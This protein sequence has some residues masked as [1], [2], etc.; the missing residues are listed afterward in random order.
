MTG[1]FYEHIA[2]GAEQSGISPEEALSRARDMGYE[3]LECDLWRLQTPGTAKPD[4]A[5]KDLFDCHDM[6]VISVYNSYDFP[7]EGKEKC[8][9]KYLPHMEAAAFFG[10]GKILCV[11]GLFRQGDDRD[12][13]M[14]RTAL[15]LS[16]MCEAARGY[17]VT[18]M[19]EDFDDIGSPC[20]RTSQLEYL[21]G[22]VPGLGVAFDTG[23]FAYCC[24][25]AVEAYGK[26]RDRVIHVHLKDRTW[27]QG[28]GKKEDISGRKMFACPAG[29]GF[30]GIRDI[31]KRLR[32]DGYSGDFSVEHF[33]ADDQ[34]RFMERS[35]ENL[36]DI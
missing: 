21:L 25:D 15:R 35:L 22:N 13:C 29:D 4:K 20:C 17:G 31:I 34:M 1:I 30:I 23:N 10:A 18:V 8:R 36:S 27:E 7:H 26:L 5:V 33:G 11:P 2:E 6:R 3:G 16:E 32:A 12:E 9:E 28:C 19:I 24:E 14:E